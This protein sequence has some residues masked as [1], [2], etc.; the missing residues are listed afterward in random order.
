V[1]LIVDASVAFKWLVKENGSDI[2]LRLLDDH[3]IV[4]PG[5][6]LAECR[7][8]ILTSVRRGKLTVDT[9]RQ[10]ERTLDALQIATIPSRPF[11]S[12]AFAIALEHSHPI[13]DCI[14]AAA[15]MES[16][17]ILVT[18]DANFHAKMV[19]SSMVRDHIRLLQ[20][21]GV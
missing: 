6:L 4:A 9:A 1:D 14:Y 2:A 5:L 11:L 12:Q 13:Y 16:H 20:T 3:D 17:R 8:A 19:A 18:A 15:A 10:V 21:F 7:N